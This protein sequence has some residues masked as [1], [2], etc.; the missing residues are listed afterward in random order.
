MKQHLVFK[1]GTVLKKVWF[2]DYRFSED[3]DFTFVEGAFDKSILEEN[4]EQALAWIF[5]TSRI[6]VENRPEETKSETQYKSNFI[7]TGPLGGEKSIKCDISTNECI[8]F[9]IEAKE[10]LDGYSDKTEK[11]NA[12]TIKVYSKEEA[13][14][15]KLRCVIQRVIPRDIYD[16]WYLTEVDGL[17]IKDVA[18]QY[19]DKTKHKELEPLDIIK[20]LD[21][22]M[23]KYHGNWDKSLKH[24]IKDLPEFE[25]VW[26]DVIRS[27]KSMVELIK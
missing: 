23:N 11:E 3:V 20:K 14:A 10:I 15:E 2:A 22:N 16:I 27:I 5:E 25:S 19:A 1:G 4:I 6:K 8:S 21:K 12:E 9:K 17:E 18:Y 7:Y 13:L 24:Q 26:R